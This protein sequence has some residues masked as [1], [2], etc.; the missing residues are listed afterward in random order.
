MKLNH[1]ELARSDRKTNSIEYRSLSTRVMGRQPGDCNLRLTKQ[2]LP[3]EKRHR[4]T[5]EDTVR[6]NAKKTNG[7]T[8]E[9][10]EAPESIISICVRMVAGAMMLIGGLPLILTFWLMPLGLLLAFVGTALIG[11]GSSTAE[12]SSD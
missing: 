2:Q 11:P 7:W 3:C 10:R 9:V 12:T 1:S 6:S 4:E 5:R 8:H